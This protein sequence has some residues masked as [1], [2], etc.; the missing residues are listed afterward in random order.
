M[1]FTRSLLVSLHNIYVLCDLCR[2]SQYF[3]LLFHLRRNKFNLPPIF[4]FSIFGLSPFS[5]NF[6]QLL[7]VF[8]TFVNCKESGTILLPLCVSVIDC[9]L[10]FIA[11]ITAT[12]SVMKTTQLLL[13]ITARFS[14]WLKMMI[15]AKLRFGLKMKWS[16]LRRALSY[17]EM[18][19][20][21]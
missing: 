20:M 18:K 5:I 11:G 19:Y 8:F 4:I 9:K 13:T 6:P 10:S 1:Y 7:C 15:T 14:F 12:S 3:P 2:W 16:E 21:N 17:F